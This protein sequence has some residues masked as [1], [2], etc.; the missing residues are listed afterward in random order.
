MRNLYSVTKS[1]QAVRDLVEAIQDLTGNMPP[2][3][4]PKVAQSPL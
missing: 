1:Q 4:Q 2:L 3:G